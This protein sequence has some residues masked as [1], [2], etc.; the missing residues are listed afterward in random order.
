MI[1]IMCTCTP[2]VNDK[3]SGANELIHVHVQT[4]WAL[5]DGHKHMLIETEQLSYRLCSYYWVKPCITSFIFVSLWLL[6]FNCCFKTLLLHFNPCILHISAIPKGNAYKLCTLNFHQ[7]IYGKERICWDNVHVCYERFER[8]N[9]IHNN[10]VFALPDH[11]SGML[12]WTCTWESSTSMPQTTTRDLPSY[13]HTRKGICSQL[14]C[15]VGCGNLIK[16][17]KYFL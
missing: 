13:L 6:F 14:V 12:W 1:C 5:P 15:S 16:P 10:S 17:R 11:C 8:L 4:I 7:H 3:T 9:V 2:S